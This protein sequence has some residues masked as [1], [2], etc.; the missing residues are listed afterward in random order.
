MFHVFC[1]HHEI[2]NT[3]KTK[4]NKIQNSKERECLHIQQE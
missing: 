1:H 2:Q 4:K 3:I